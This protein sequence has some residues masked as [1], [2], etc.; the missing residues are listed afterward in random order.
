MKFGGGNM[1][2]DIDLDDGGDLEGHNQDNDVDTAFP[3][4]KSYIKDA[5]QVSFSGNIVYQNNSLFDFDQATS[6]RTSGKPVAG[7]NK[8]RMQTGRAAIGKVDSRPI[9]LHHI[10]QTQGG[11]IIELPQWFHQEKFTELHT[12]TGRM[13]SLINRGTFNTWRRDYWK[14]RGK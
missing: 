6:W 3:I 14:D 4:L 9:N 5:T 13:P 10:T 8:D 2:S 7:T 11:A 12:N 1:D